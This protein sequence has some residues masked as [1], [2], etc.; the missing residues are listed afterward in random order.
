MM[1]PAPAVDSRT[2]TERRGTIFLCRDLYL[3]QELDEVAGHLAADGFFVRRGEPVKP[4]TKRV[5]NAE[6]RAR[7]LADADVVVVSS[8][9]LLSGED[10]MAA[11]RLR[12]VIAPTI[13]VDAIDLGAAERLGIIVG[14]GATPENFLSMAEATA[15]LMMVLFYDLHGTERVL[16]QGLPRPR[17][18]KAR[19]LRGST[20]G[21]IGFGRI[22]RA[23]HERLAG[24]DT[25]IL[26]RDPF[27]A[28]NALPPGV[29]LVDL[30]TLLRES[31]LVSLHVTLDASTRGM[32]G[33]A[34][35]QAMKPGSFIINTARGGL[36]DEAA[37]FRCLKNG[38]VAGAALDNFETEPL[39]ADSPLRQLDNVILT[40]HMVGHTRDVMASLAPALHENIRRVMRGELPLHPKNP[41]VAEAWRQR[42]RELE[43]TG[44][45]EG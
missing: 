40:P 44:R 36:I 6:S 25:R 4:G 22:A 17:T 38:H 27:L 23:V 11:R 7:L 29:R 42:L 30:D 35:L 45:N 14:H 37:L 15:M 8:R 5:F 26:V 32:I 2:E 16:R 34:Q 18:M 20:I 41:Q 9:N 39:P 24:W 43:G 3:D 28:A 1:S 31:D 21:L 10:M 33:E 13:G 12:A 19:M